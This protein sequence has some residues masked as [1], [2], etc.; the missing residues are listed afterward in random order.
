MVAERK[1]KNEDNMN[2]VK[3]ELVELSGPG[4]NI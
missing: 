3:H 4:G 2:S 1:T